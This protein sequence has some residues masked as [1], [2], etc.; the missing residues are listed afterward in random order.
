MLHVKRWEIVETE[1]CGMFAEKI[2]LLHDIQQ[3]FYLSLLKK[4]H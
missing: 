3:P 2:A 4:G 1:L